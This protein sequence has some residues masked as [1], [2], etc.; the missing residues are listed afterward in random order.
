MQKEIGQLRGKLEFVTA[1]RDHYFNLVGDRT[2]QLQRKAKECRA[3]K[4][5]LSAM[6]RCPGVD[7]TDQVTGQTFRTLLNG[8]ASA[9]GGDAP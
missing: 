9:K 1:S 2:K 3:L 8:S 4:R 6:T 7:N 5:R